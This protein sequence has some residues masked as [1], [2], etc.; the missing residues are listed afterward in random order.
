MYV[1]GGEEKCLNAGKKISTVFNQPNTGF[2]LLPAGRKKPPREGFL[3]NPYSFQEI[4]KQK[5]GRNVGIIAGNG[6]IIFDVDDPSAFNGLDLPKS[7]KWETRPGRYATRFKCDD[8]VASLVKRKIHTGKSKLE[9]F[10][11]KKLDEISRYPAIGEIKLERTYQLIPPSWE[12]LDGNRTEYRFL[13]GGEIAPHPISL[14]W[15]PDSLREID[16]CL[17]SNPADKDASMGTVASLGAGKKETPTDKP[18]VVNDLT[19]IELVRSNLA[20]A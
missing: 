2:V 1:N 14:H 15:L 18:L 8:C 5:G 7:S 4:Q 3:E 19:P 6:Y 11:S 12:E 17:S 9:L 20:N 16:I 10:D 13:D